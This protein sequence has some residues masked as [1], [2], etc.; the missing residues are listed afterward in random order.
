MK[1]EQGAE[2]VLH[3]SE[4]TVTKERVAKAYRH[5][6]LDEKLRKLRNRKEAKILG[7]A[8]TRVPK[9]IAVTDY[10]ITMERIDGPRLRDVL[11]QENA[12]HHGRE[13][14][15]MIKELHGKNI[16]HGDLTTSN[17][18]VDKQG[19]VL[20]DFGLSAHSQ[21]K[22]D[23]AVDLHV[24]RETLEGTHVKE[25]EQFWEAFATAYADE[26]ILT[27]LTEVESRGRYKAKY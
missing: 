25:K 1:S 19:I 14:G 22:E 17:A 15:A 18:L 23:R 7:E 24:L 27:L 16:I 20:I 8:P 26:E 2:A 21:R 5:P 12:A 4:H 3:F 11:T 6:E 13:L 9:L 10:S